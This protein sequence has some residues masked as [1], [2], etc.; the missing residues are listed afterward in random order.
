MILLLLASTVQ[1]IAS[2]WHDGQ[3]VTDKEREVAQVRA[4]NDRLKRAIA[5]VE[6]PEHVE[7]VARDKLNLAKPGEVVVIVPSE[8]VSATGS[9]GRQTLPNWQRWARLFW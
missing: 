7:E 9:V 1:A 2:F 5:E 3:K 4:E 8:L 6:T